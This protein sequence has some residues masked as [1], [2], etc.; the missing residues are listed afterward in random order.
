M[1]II[2]RFSLQPYHACG[3]WSTGDSSAVTRQHIPHA[4]VVPDLTNVWLGDRFYKP[5][6]DWGTQAWGV[7]SGGVIATPPT[8]RSSPP[9]TSTHKKTKTFGIGDHYSTRQSACWPT[10]RWI[11]A[12]I[13]R[14]AIALGTPLTL[15]PLTGTSHRCLS[16]WDSCRPWARDKE[17]K[18][19]T[20]QIKGMH[21]HLKGT[22]LQW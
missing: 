9:G 8:P 17:L 14:S 15:G 11:H 7:S 4:L 16:A 3:V 22:C 12:T 20:H 21:A 13:A 10:T 1:W 18:E 2:R 6:P 5:R 19:F